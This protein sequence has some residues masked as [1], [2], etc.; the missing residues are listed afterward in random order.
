MLFAILPAL[1]STRADAGEALKDGGTRSAGGVRATRS[2]SV[3][4]VA[5]LGLAVMLLVLAT[6]LTQA[7]VAITAVPIGVDKDRLLTARLDLPSWRYRQRC[8]DRAVPRSA[9]R[10]IEG[11]PGDQG[12]GLD[13]PTANPRRGADHRGRD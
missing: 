5:Q 6:L 4:I 1:Y 2:R 9:G 7:L 3:L 10:A 13:R 11:E 8:R 12:R